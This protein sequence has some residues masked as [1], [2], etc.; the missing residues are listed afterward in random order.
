MLIVFDA[1]FSS[2]AC[3]ASSQNALDIWGAT[4]WTVGKNVTVKASN[5]NRGQQLF[6]NVLQQVQH[7]SFKNRKFQQVSMASG[8][9]FGTGGSKVQILSPRP[10]FSIAYN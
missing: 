3:D 5:F 9:W 2:R 4:Q 10:I 7:Q 8:I 1:A 6:T